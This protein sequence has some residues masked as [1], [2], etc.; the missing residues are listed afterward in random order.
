MEPLARRHRF[1]RRWRSRMVGH[2]PRETLRSLGVPVRHELTGDA[3]SNE[4][5]VAGTRQFGTGHRVYFCDPSQRREGPQFLD[6]SG[7]V[8]RIELA[9]SLNRCKLLLVLAEEVVGQRHTGPVAALPF[10]HEPTL[11]IELLQTP[12]RFTRTQGPQRG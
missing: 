6:E 4:I 3:E 5:G 7:R 12:Q 11:Q 8:W 10:P 9:E 1:R 2:V